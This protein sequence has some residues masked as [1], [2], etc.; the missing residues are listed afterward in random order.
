M[1]YSSSTTAYLLSQQQLLTDLAAAAFTFGAYKT[2]QVRVD[3]VEKLTALDLGQAL[4]DSDPFAAI[5]AAAGP[6]ELKRFA[7]AVL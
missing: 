4:R 1:G 5:A 3:D 7:Q 2:F 6:I